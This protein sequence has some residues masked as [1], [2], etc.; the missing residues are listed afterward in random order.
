MGIYFYK[1]GAAGSGYRLLYQNHKYIG[2]FRDA[3]VVH[4]YSGSYKAE[5]L[6]NDAEATGMA[7]SA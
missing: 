2:H 3:C 4:Y 5:R 6:K 1:A 7:E